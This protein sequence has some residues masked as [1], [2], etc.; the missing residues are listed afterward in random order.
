MARELPS[1][2]CDRRVARNAVSPEQTRAE[3]DYLERVLS[4]QPRSRVLDVPCGYRRHSLEL[5]AR[6]FEVRAVDVSMEMIVEAERSAAHDRLAI[7][8]RREDMR[9][10]SWESEFDAAFCLETALDISTP[11]ARGRS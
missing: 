4:L 10:L 1:G 5:A 8:C 7:E 9:D 3:V 6:G 2:H 11:W